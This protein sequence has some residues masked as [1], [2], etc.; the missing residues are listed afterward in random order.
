MISDV[1]AQ[2]KINEDICVMKKMI[3]AQI[4]AKLK[5]IMQKA[6]QN[7]LKIE[8]G[9]ELK[10]LLLCDKLKNSLKDRVHSCSHKHERH[11]SFND[12]EQDRDT[13]ANE[14]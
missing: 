9:D 10:K 6:D 4:D 2:I 14:K 12:R 7:K 11:F 8:S 1:R 5:K 13:H 3:E